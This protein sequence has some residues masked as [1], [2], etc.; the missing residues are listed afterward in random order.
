MTEK[1]AY[2]PGEPTWIDLSTPDLAA[3]VAFYGQL[4]GWQAGPSSE[5]FGGYTMFTQDGRAVAGVAPLM[6][7]A[8]P[9]A[10]SSYICVADVDATTALVTGNGGGVLVPAMDIPN[11]G[12]MAVYTDPAGAAISAWQAHGHIG[13]E[14]RDDE[15][16]L[17]WNDLTTRDQDKVLP[18]YR[19]VF[20]WGAQ[21]SEDYTEFHLGTQPV[22]GCMDMPEAIPGEIPSYWMPYFAAADPAAKAQQVAALGGT[23]LVPFMDFGSGTCAVVQDPYGA[24]FGLMSFAG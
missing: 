2:R 22:A 24:T 3:S 17:A 23:V 21:A 20:G 1:T 16:T 5:E 7:A 8:Q 4:F 15:G 19:A 14:L 13:A 10:W 11:A 9:P 12:R 6:D 18:F